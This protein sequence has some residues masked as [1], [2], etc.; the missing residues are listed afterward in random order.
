MIISNFKWR[1]E[2]FPLC[3]GKGGNNWD[4]AVGQQYLQ[5]FTNAII[6][7]AK[8]TKLCKS[9]R[10]SKFFIVGGEHKKVPL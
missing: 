8:V 10:L 3:G 1:I 6:L 7:K 9:Q 2:N 5:S 4:L